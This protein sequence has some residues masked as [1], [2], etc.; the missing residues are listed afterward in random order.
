AAAG[1]SIQQKFDAGELSTLVRSA[2]IGLVAGKTRHA[3]HTDGD[4]VR[5]SV[6]GRE[7]SKEIS[8]DGVLFPSLVLGLGHL[9]LRVLQRLRQT[10]HTEFGSADQL[11]CCRLLY[12]D[13]DPDALREAAKPGRQAA[14]SP[15]EVLIAKLNRPSHY[16]RSHD[17]RKLIDSWFNLKMLYRIPRTLVTAGVRALGRL[18]FFD[19]H[20]LISRRL[21]NELEACTLSENLTA[22]INNTGLGLRSN[23]P[24]V[25]V[26]TSL[27][28]GTGS[29]MFLDLAYLLRGLLRGLGY[30]HADVHGVFLLA[31]IDRHPSNTV[32]IGNTFAALTELNHFSAPHNPFTARYGEN[33][34]PVTDAGAPYDRSIMLALRPESD[35]QRTSR[36]LNQMAELL[37]RALTTA[38][39]RAAD[40]ARH[41][42]ETF[43]P[44]SRTLLCQSFGMSRIV[45]PRRA[46][47]TS[48]A[49][50]LCK[51]VVD[52][53]MSKDG[54]ALRAR[55]R[56]M[57]HDLWAKEKI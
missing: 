38:L 41:R 12:L 50:R 34:E 35:E 44:S 1:E 32:A 51:E 54:E 36:D 49:R 52:H 8:G 53:W 4:P 11:P 2:A 21:L 25:Y 6:Y 14:L 37:F 18:A 7:P 40:D 55:S 57:V 43:S 24:S 9:G 45:W 20:R 26:V 10:I 42:Y 19:N 23:R 28:G 17:E 16:L 29:G 47:V 27:A 31:G 22:A 15:Q 13:T 5:G 48:V 33:T 56:S 3:G 46:F 39:G 30:R